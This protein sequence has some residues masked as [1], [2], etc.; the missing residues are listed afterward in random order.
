MSRRRNGKPPEGGSYQVQLREAMSRF[1]PKGLATVSGD[2]RVRWV[3]RLLVVCAVLMAWDPGP[4]LAD[5]FAAARACV[6]RMFPGRRRPG[7]T[8]EGFA[9]ALLRASAGLLG[10]VAASLRA[11]V[12]SAAVAGG[13]WEV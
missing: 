10:V 4:T 12:R 5:R 1:L 8:H 6:V 13:C 3:E 11:S 2:A 7:G 9:A